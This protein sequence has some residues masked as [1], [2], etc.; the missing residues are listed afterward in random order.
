L[1]ESTRPEKLIE[2]IDRRVE[3]EAEVAAGKADTGT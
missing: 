3:K 1:E 2:Q